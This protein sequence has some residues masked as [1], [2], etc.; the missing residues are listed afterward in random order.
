MRGQNI[1][2]A[3]LNAS[4]NVPHIR[5]KGVTLRASHKFLD[6][7]WVKSSDE[8]QNYCKDLEE[9]KDGDV[10]DGEEPPQQLSP[11]NPPGPTLSPSQSL[12]EVSRA[13]FASGGMVRPLSTI[14]DSASNTVVFKLKPNQELRFEIKADSNQQARKTT[15]TLV[16]QQGGRAEICGAEL[17]AGREYVQTHT[18]ESLFFPICHPVTGTF[19]DMRH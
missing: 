13:G 4:Q 8:I 1:S 11:E 3:V 2:I 10:C 18:Y 15:A 7:S 17:F 6:Y 12:E 9:L 14:G 5:V 19:F 16:L